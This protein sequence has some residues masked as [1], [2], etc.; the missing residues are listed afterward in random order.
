MDFFQYCT[1]YQVNQYLPA[2]RINNY[3]TFSPSLGPCLFLIGAFRLDKAQLWLGSTSGS[4]CPPPPAK[5]STAQHNH[6]VHH[7]HL[8]TS[9]F[10][11]NHQLARP[12]LFF[13]FLFTKAPY[14]D[15]YYRCLNSPHD[16]HPAYSPHLTHRPNE[17]IVLL[18]AQHSFRYRNFSPRRHPC[19]LH[20]QLINFQKPHSART[21]SC[22][23]SR[24]YN[25]L[26]ATSIALARP[27]WDTSYFFILYHR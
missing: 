15:R 18:S 20:Q 10:F 23:L 6:K 9:P 19:L 2:R 22:C 13:T 25:S 24:E 17:L 21:R 27:P 4:P 8:R 7:H 1:L 3:N 5:Q 11:A 12:D 16:I 26:K 14:L